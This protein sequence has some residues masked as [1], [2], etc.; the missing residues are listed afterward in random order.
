MNNFEISNL[1]HSAWVVYKRNNRENILN[2]YP[3]FDFESRLFIMKEFKKKFE[4]LNLRL[5]L[6]DG[7]LLGAVREKKFIPWDNDVDLHVLSEEIDDEKIKILKNHFLKLGCIVR[8]VDNYPDQKMNV[9]YKG[10]KVGILLLYENQNFRYRHIYRWPKFLYEE[11]E[12]IEFLG[13]TFM[14]PKINDY[15]IHQY[16]NDWKVPKK[17]NYFSKKLTNF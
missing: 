6:A 17:K 12:S 16:G 2:T 9:F 13:E 11:S 5:Y 1:P 14:T 15:L 3:N 10:E 8:T 7:A 4:E